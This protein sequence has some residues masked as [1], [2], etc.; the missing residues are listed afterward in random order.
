MIDPNSLSRYKEI[1]SITEVNINLIRNPYI[2]RQAELDFDSLSNSWIIY[3]NNIQSEFPIIQELGHI[4]FA[5]NKTSYMNFA[6]PPPQS[7]ELNREMGELINNLLDC[8]INYS[9]SVFEEIYPVIQQNDFFYLDNLEIFRTRI[10]ST[11]NRYMLLGWY[12]L[13][14]IDFGFILKP[15][16]RDTRNQ[17]IDSFLELLRSQVCNLFG[18]NTR[19]MREL[20]N[21]LNGFNSAKDEIQHVRIIYFIYNVLSS[22]NLWPTQELQRQIRL[23]FP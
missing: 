13:F 7:R 6:L 8:F 11:S 3:Y 5:L 16:D 18:F 19:D 9:L 17:D 22:L 14:Y 1:L 21:N 12:I 4:Y 15:E 23:F 10:E 20:T 2:N